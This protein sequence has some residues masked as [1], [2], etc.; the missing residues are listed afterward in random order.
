[1]KKTFC[2]SFVMFIVMTMISTVFFS[3]CDNKIKNVMLNKTTLTL[4]V[5]ASETLILTVEP[6]D[7]EYTAI[8]ESSNNEIV[9]VDKKGK[10]TAI[11]PGTATVTVTVENKKASCKITVS[12]FT[13]YIEYNGKKY[14][15]ENGFWKV[16]GV[17]TWEGINYSLI[18][19][20][21]K[22]VKYNSFMENIFGTGNGMNIMITHTGYFPSITNQT[23][24]FGSSA[25]VN[26]IFTANLLFNHDSWSLTS[27]TAISIQSG[28]LSLSKSASTYTLDFIGQDESGKSVK[29]H[30]MGSLQELRSPFVI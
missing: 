21:S 18:T 27:N 19:I 29:M 26:H 1:M 10:I 30:F 14:G 28:T 24:I 11:S 2:T 13:Y 15:L 7:A 3:A 22:E 17:T 8:W 6:A 5:N 9:T 4:A 25:E 12:D 20:V 23:Y 16:A